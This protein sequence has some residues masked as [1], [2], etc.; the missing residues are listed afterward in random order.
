MRGLLSGV[1]A[2]NANFFRGFFHDFGPTGV[3]V[4]CSISPDAGLHYQDQIGT[5]L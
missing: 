1:L 3:T 2:E 5:I 4:R